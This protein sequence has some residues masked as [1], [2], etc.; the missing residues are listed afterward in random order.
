MMRRS[1][2]ARINTPNPQYTNQ[3]RNF[4][5]K[6]FT[7]SLL[8]SFLALTISTSAF[9]LSPEQIQASLN[10]P[11]VREVIGEKQIKSLEAGPSAR[12]MGCFGITLSLYNEATA[13][14]INGVQRGE[15]ISIWGIHSAN[16]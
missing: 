16:D 15:E 3:Q 1:A 5:M 8:S 13:Y 12:C 11:R 9:A 10:D 2:A 6:T 7:F 14:Q 4:F